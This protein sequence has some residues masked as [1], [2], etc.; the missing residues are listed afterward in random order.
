MTK[1]QDSVDGKISLVS[2]SGLTQ[3][4]QTGSQIGLGGLRKHPSLS[5]L[6]ELSTQKLSMPF[7][8]FRK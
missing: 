7:S 4:P 5:Y 1:L 3:W 2:L 8:S 6:V